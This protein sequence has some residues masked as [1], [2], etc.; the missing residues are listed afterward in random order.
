MGIILDKIQSYVMIADTGNTT[1]RESS[2]R[3]S[4][5]G[6]GSTESLTPDFMDKPRNPY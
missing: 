5:F 6:T 1:P 4:L 3:N 2:I